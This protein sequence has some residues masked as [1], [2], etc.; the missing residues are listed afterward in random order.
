MRLVLGRTLRIPALAAVVLVPAITLAA[1][2][3]RAYR[4]EAVLLKERFRED[5]AAIVRLVAGRVSDT[6]RKTLEELEDRF[7]AEDPDP[8]LEAR[9]LSSH[10][11]AL[12]VFV[13]RGGRLTYPETRLEDRE[14]GEV[15]PLPA[16]DLQIQNYVR[17]AREARLLGAI[18][19][20]GL[21]AEVRGSPELAAQLYERAR[22]GKGEAAARALLGIARLA[23]RAGDAAGAARA[24][25]EIAQRFP[26]LQSADRVSY[27]LLADAGAAEAGPPSRL[28]DLFASLE[29]RRYAT[30]AESRRY[31]LEWTIQRLEAVRSVDRAKLAELRRASERHLSS[32][33]F[34]ALLER[35]GLPELER[36]AGEG[37]SGVAL[38]R[39]TVLV[40]GSVAGGVIG[41]RLDERF[42]TGLVRRYATEVVPKERGISLALQ[43]S[44][45]LPARPDAKLLH[46]A[47]LDRPLRPFVLSAVLVSP[48]PVD[49]LG[50]RAE[51]L[52]LGLTAGLVAVL[53]GGLL[54]TFRAVRRET[55]L[56]RLKADLASNVSHELKTPL[57]AIRMYAEML[58]EGIAATPEDRRRY[59]RV[60]LKES[61]R[62][63][64]LI[65]NVLDFSRIERGTR[66]YDLAAVDLSALAREAV[67]T[68]GLLTEGERPS[69]TLEDD[70]GGRSTVL[71]DRE[72]VLQSI[73]NL[74]SNAAK[75]SP[76]DPR[77][78]VLVHRR[79]GQLGLRVRD[80]GIGIPASEQGRIFDDFYRAPTARRAGVEGTGLGLALVRRHV[81]ACGG[82]VV[83]ESTPG[84]G[85]EFTLWFRE[86][87]PPAGE[88]AVEA[89]PGTA[90]AGTG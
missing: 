33:R 69:V 34:G 57:T 17:R 90:P 54:L 49:R 11:I 14:G 89:A 48:G 22:S 29:A 21:A 25:A 28:L 24:V 78:E 74:L 15:A 42:L 60:I 19:A 39:G 6:A 68:F 53:L 10:P 84:K 9:F 37:P 43:R 40:L 67:E 58:E 63:G 72:A 85:S 65:A 80:H 30:S 38:D 79:D 52:Q 71:A 81:T 44:L 47:V 8:S 26:T 83:L 13:A 70:T 50:Q 82:K 86:A 12:Q 35:I 45:D 88:A 1:L 59:H 64:R 3:L 4:T 20:R 62:L 77:I 41:Y 66:R 61:E 73:L 51:L 46:T 23:R 16:S 2:G 7:K 27:A 36:L 5:Q 75:Y 18:V 76:D 31:Y 55:E 56:A 32:M 87:P